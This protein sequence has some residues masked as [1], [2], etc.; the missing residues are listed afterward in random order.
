MPLRGGPGVQAQP[1]R[2]IP[3]N[4]QASATATSRG[5]AADP[6]AWSELSLHSLCKA[7]RGSSAGG[8]PRALPVN[9]LHCGHPQT[10]PSGWKHGSATREGG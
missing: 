4:T 5:C 10:H 3:L 8:P 2:V 7:T 1:D 6:R 9:A